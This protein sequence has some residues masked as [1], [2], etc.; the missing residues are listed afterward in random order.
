[1]AVGRIQTGRSSLRNAPRIHRSTVAVAFVVLIVL[2]VLNVPGEIVSPLGGNFGGGYTASYES[3]WP[4]IHQQRAVEYVFSDTGPNMPDFPLYGIPWLAIDSWKFWEADQMRVHPRALLANAAI[5]VAVL[6]SITF[7]WERRRRRVGRF[8][9]RLAEFFMAIT[10]VAALFGWYGYFIREFNRE[11]PH[12][13]ALWEMDRVYVYDAY[14]PPLWFRRI[15]GNAHLSE[16]FF[17]ADSVEFDTI[18]EPLLMRALPH[19]RS[20]KYLRHLRVSDEIS[21][22]LDGFS[23]LAD[24]SSLR[25]LEINKRLTEIDVAELAALGQ[26]HE[27]SLAWMDDQDPELI[28][29]LARRL[30]DCRVTDNCTWYDTYGW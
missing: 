6:V 30:P 8:Q 21:G 28:R 13:D 23:M 9:F 22:S 4:F 1:M 12:V 16:A 7:Y 27:I 26:L 3:G 29:E 20:L 15:V 25:Y 5:A 19:L 14:S 11:K 17:R 18:D 10:L 2:A 24:L